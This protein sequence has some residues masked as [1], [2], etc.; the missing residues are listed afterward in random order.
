M[1]PRTKKVTSEGSISEWRE[2][3]SPDQLITAEYR[4]LIEVSVAMRKYPLVA[5]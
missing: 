4:N 2:D 1:A 5:N 3:E